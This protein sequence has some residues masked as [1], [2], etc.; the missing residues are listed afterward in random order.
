MADR[1]SDSYDGVPEEANIAVRVPPKAFKQL[2]SSSDA[3]KA[4][5]NQKGLKSLEKAARKA[6]EAARNEGTAQNQGDSQGGT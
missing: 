2:S 4:K 1:R 3:V 5:R 6:G